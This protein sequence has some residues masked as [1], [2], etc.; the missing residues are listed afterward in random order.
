[1]KKPVLV[2][3]PT[4]GFGGLICQVFEESGLYQSYYVANYQQAQTVLEVFNPDLFIFDQ[5][6]H[7]RPLSDYN[8]LVR[9][10]APKS[11]M[12]F[13]S[14]GESSNLPT[15]LGDIQIDAVLSKPFF[16]PDL[17]E[18]ANQVMGI[19]KDKQFLDET[20]PLK[21]SQSGGGEDFQEAVS[22][23]EGPDSKAR[24]LIT[25]PPKTTVP[26]ILESPE[27][28]VQCLRDFSSESDALHLIILHQ[29]SR[30][31]GTGRLL[32]EEEN[33]LVESI[34]TN[35]SDD[36][37]SDLARFV[38]LG[39]GNKEYMLYARRIS[40]GFI[41]AMVFHPDTQFSRIRRQANSLTELIVRP[42]E[43]KYLQYLGE[44]RLRERMDQK[45]G[46]GCGEEQKSEFFD[47]SGLIDEISINEEQDEQS[48]SE[49]VNSELNTL[50]E[51]G[52]IIEWEVELDPE[53]DAQS[54]LL[55]DVPSSVPESWLR[56]SPD[57]EVDS[58]EYNPE[59]DIELG[60]KNEI[61]QDMIPLAD[62]V[63]YN[64][65]EELLFSG[66]DFIAENDYREFN[67]MDTD[68][69]P[70]IDSI[71]T[72]SFEA[73]ST[74]L[75]DETVPTQILTDTGGVEYNMESVSPAMYSLSFSCVL[76]ARLPKHFLTGEIAE[77]LSER[78][79]ELCVAFGWRLEKLAIQPEYLHWVVSVPP[80]TSPG[81]LMRIIRQHTSR[82]L[83]SVFPRLQ[84]ENPSGD[85]WAPG[86]LIMSGSQ[87]SSSKM[88]QEFI[89]QTR[90][91]QGIIR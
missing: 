47:M 39:A 89:H 66:D 4:E 49:S 21:N 86:Y 18:T 42:D 43:K 24:V 41:L 73:F 17:L 28:T 55:E 79:S 81:Y 30:F 11:K 40:E 34:Q 1:M 9:G 84:V 37:G 68:G 62:D 60:Q 6:V 16:P 12:I 31:T 83:F 65:E 56:I 53:I 71:N 29:A 82:H 58:Q 64:R 67:T 70:D 15:T 5:D 76:L 74:P 87:K 61:S 44:S 35:W 48:Q 25:P 32:P 54:P 7:D 26:Q 38:R 91:R 88:I 45:S 10:N 57:Y 69:Y 3:T 8:D 36:H 63:I 77:S 14:S 33:Q 80:S 72:P 51:Q 90:S 23:Q 20:K 85:F 19:P 75:E 13:I 27:I 22:F 78:I 2:F 46:C 50:E 52:F 59:A